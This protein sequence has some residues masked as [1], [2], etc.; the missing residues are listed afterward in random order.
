MTSPEKVAHQTVLIYY[1]PDITEAECPDFWNATRLLLKNGL[2]M[3]L[4]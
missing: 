3:L 4:I 1:H 2:R